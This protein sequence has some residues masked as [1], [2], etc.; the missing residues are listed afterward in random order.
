M[1]LTEVRYSPLLAPAACILAAYFVYELGKSLRSSILAVGIAALLFVLS[2]FL[3]QPPFFGPSGINQQFIQAAEWINLNTPSNST[4][5]TLWP[6]GSV[7]EAIAQRPEFTD[8]MMAAQR[9][10]SS[11]PR[12]LYARAGNL[13]LDG[14][15]PDYLLVRRWW[16]NESPAIQ[17]EGAEYQPGLKYSPYN[18]SN[19]EAL[20]NGSMPLP[21]VY[22]NNDSLVY[23]WAACGR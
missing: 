13:T 5:I 14:L 3:M 21:L 23:C 4:V 2:I 17:Y 8:S 18:G 7:V 10:W 1:Q 11:F 12:F 20:E 19:F 15:H 16:L 9:L 22:G 6:D